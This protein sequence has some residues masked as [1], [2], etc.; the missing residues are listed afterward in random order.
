MKMSKQ[1]RIG[2]LIILSVVLLALGAFL[3]VKP[4]FEEVGVTKGRLESKQ[5]E[6]KTLQDKQARKAPL[7]DSILQAYEVGA[8]Q[9]DMFFPEMASYEAEDAF[10]EF[11]AQC[12]SNI[13]VQEVTVSQPTTATLGATFLNATNVSYPLKDYATQ[14]VQQNDEEA[15][16]AARMQAIQNAL[17]GSQTIGASNIEFTVYALTFQDLIK[18]TDEINEYMKDEN[19]TSVRKAIYTNGLSLEYD[20]VKWLY[21]AL[22]KIDTEYMDAL[23]T[24]E[25]N[26][27]AGLDLEVPDVAGPIVPGDTG[28]LG[29]I[30]EGGEVSPSVSLGSDN[31]ELQRDPTVND[32]VI[33]FPMVI[34]FYSLERMQDPTAQLNAQDGITE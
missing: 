16:L 11:L 27:L 7:R 30:G 17:S 18:F 28:E 13:V 5:T 4:A 21:E 8:H 14:G 26:K 19:G 32:Y 6:L 31:E 33:E 29:E 10:R 22:A 3:I 15:A 2:L 34:T 24:A 9:A 12:K 25:L 1:E 20:L 23:G